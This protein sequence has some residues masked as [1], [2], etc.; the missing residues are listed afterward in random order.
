[1]SVVVGTG[2]YLEYFN[3]PV[4]V[5]QGAIGSA[6]AAGSIAGSLAAGY[7][8]DRFGRRDAIWG[9]CFFW[10]VGTAIQTGVQNWQMLLAG[11][12]I[13]GVTVGIT[14]SQVPVY[15][16]EVA[17]HDKR[18][19]VIIIQ[20]LAIDVGFTI[21][22]FIGYA[23]SFIPG[24]ASFRATWVIQLVPCVVLMVGLLF[25]PES[26]RWLA[27]KDR[28][29]EA[30][31]VL[32]KIQADGNTEDPMVIAEWEEIITTLQAEREVGQGWRK[33]VKNGMWRRTSV[34]FMVQAWQQLAGAASLS[35]VT[36]RVFLN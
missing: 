31:S 28:V 20:Q 34:G 21:Y 35:P 16:A 18:G 14:S 27:S 6:L 25:L 11:R 7:L 5:R 30:I 32:A 10:V 13:N 36:F 23:C 9:S 19:S 33:F 29:E 17:K 22:F 8:S 24:P 3:N 26:P 2:Q 1:M 15:L 12:I 4:G